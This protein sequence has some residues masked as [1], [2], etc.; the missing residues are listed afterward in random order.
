MA[1]ASR[2]HEESCR[3]GPGRASCGRRSPGHRGT[4]RTYDRRLA[5][6][7]AYRSA[8]NP[9]DNA[10]DQ[11]PAPRD[12]SPPS[13]PAPCGP[14]RAPV[15]ARRGAACR[16]GSKRAL[17]QHL[18]PLAPDALSRT[19]HA[20]R[21]GIVQQDVA[22][23]ALLPAAAPRAKERRILAPEQVK[24][25]EEVLAGEDGEGLWLAMALLG[26]RPGEAAALTWQDVDLEAGVLHVV[27]AR[28]WTPLPRSV[29][30]RRPRRILLEPRTCRE[31]TAVDQ[32]RTGHETGS[33]PP[34]P[35]RPSIHG[36]LRPPV[37]VRR[38][39]QER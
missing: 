30:R 10:Q 37:D 33:G 14:T 32:R 28:K 5:R 35:L 25:L 3:A 7:L 18:P 12:G 39:R 15:R 4:G 26:L 20:E 19:G 27:Q 17:S 2:H 22:K 31:T 16:H 34:R 36:S 23:L 13:P 1:A 9:G 6:A 21:R 29:P 38:C 8:A 24:A 11:E